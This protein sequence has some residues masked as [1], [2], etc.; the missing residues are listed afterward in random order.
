MA[1]LAGSSKM[2]AHGRK[3]ISLFNEIP[4]LVA[5]SC[6]WS[7]LGRVGPIIFSYFSFLTSF[8][9]CYFSAPKFDDLASVSTNNETKVQKLLSLPEV[10]R[11]FR[12][13]FFSTQESVSNTE[14]ST[15]MIPAVIFSPNIHMILQTC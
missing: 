5:R 13:E 10:K 3:S 11:S 7:G 6:P 15:G 1:S 2:M 4:S 12:L 8:F 9:F 14:M